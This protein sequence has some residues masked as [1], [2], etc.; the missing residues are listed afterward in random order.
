MA[1]IAVSKISNQHL[2]AR[3]RNQLLLKITVLGTGTSQGIPVIGCE[4]E[5]CQSDDPKDKRLRVSIMVETQGK[6]IVVDIGPDFRQQMLR[7]NVKKVDAILLT[8]EHTDHIIG[9]D[10]VRPFNFRYEMDMPIYGEKRVLDIIQTKRFDYIFESNPY[11]GVPR[12]LL[13]KIDEHS[14]FKVEGIEIQPIRY[15]HKYLPVL[16]FRFGDFTYMT[17]IKS[18]SDEELEKVKGTKYLIIS[19][20][21]KQQHL[22]HLTL[23]EALELIKKIRPQQ[24]WL[25]HLSHDMGKHEDVS[26]ELPPHVAIA[27][28]GLEFE[29]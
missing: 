10:D 6:T 13:N 5:V 8:H 22:S 1:F 11:P 26:K 18:I 21:R 14:S 25:T 7:V 17:D 24:A 9:L 27:Y 28:D 16:G 15:L 23:D 4:C 20:L 3:N 19:A 2:V 29:I 12:V